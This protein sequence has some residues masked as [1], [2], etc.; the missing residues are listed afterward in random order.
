LRDAYE[1]HRI[2]LNACGE[3]VTLA[4]VQ[5]I[6]S[7]A[8]NPKVLTPNFK[9]RLAYSTSQ[10]PFVPMSFKIVVKRMGFVIVL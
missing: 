6:N 9:S 1:I 3:I 5:R 7:S 8:Q 10:T 4:F 2:W